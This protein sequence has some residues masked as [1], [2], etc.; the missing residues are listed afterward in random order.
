MSFLTREAK[1]KQAAI[2]RIFWLAEKK[3]FWFL[4]WRLGSH[5]LTLCNPV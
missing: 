2:V 5:E 3:L 1:S 4:H